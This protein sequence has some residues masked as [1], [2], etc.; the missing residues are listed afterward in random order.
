MREAAAHHSSERFAHFVVTGVR[1]FVQDSLRGKD[2]AAEAK[3]ALRG[4]FIHKCLL[5][6]MRFLGR[7]QAFQSRDAVLANRS[8]RHHA[9]AHDL[10][11]KDDAASSE[12]CHSAPELRST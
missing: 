1:F 9:R 2:H 4:P 10:M 12:L 7:A 5:D 11:A 3:A 6:R 8:H